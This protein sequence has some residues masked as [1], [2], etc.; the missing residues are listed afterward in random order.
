MESPRKQNPVLA[1]CSEASFQILNGDPTE[2]WQLTVCSLRFPAEFDVLDLLAGC[3]SAKPAENRGYLFP[4]LLPV[5][6]QSP[7]IQ[8]QGLMEFGIEDWI[9]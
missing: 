8:V 4:N 2:F 3:S 5:F 6:D 1:Y 7:G 9:C